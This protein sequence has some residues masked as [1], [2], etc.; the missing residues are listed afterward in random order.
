[1]DDTSSSLHDS[2]LAALA[3]LSRGSFVS[4]GSRVLPPPERHIT[5]ATTDLPDITDIT[6]DTSDV[7]GGNGGS[8]RTVRPASR[9]FIGH[10]TILLVEDEENLRALNARGLESRG[11]TVLQAG[12]GIE[13]VNVMQR[14]G[15]KVDLVISEVVMS[16]ID[17]PTLLRQ[18]RR[19]NPDMNFMVVSGIPVVA[20][21]RHLPTDGSQFDFLP[22]PFTLKQL[23]EKV[24]DILAGA[25]IEPRGRARRRAT[26]S[27]RDHPEG[28]E[29]LAESLSREIKREID[30]LTNQS[31][32]DPAWKDQI[33]FLKFVSA[34]LDQIAAAISD[35]RQAATPDAQERKFAEAETLA[36]KLAKA[37]RD[38]AELHYERVIDYGCY[39]TF[40]VLGTQ[41]FVSLFGVPAEEALLAQLALLGVFP[42][43]KQ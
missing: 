19:R 36:S 13:A 8:G 38:F 27:F 20:F 31:R 39:S 11:Y 9:D 21:Q 12:S 34:A 30:R 33:D 14:V 37:G 43:K 42:S 25:P 16:G 40:V 35:A 26:V 22:K 41:L 24:A 32:N 17:G 4:S 29:K 2:A 5:F 1:M 7:S 10:G 6:L 28:A 18:L 3:R 15:G 23:V